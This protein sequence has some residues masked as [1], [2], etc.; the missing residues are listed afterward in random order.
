MQVIEI[1]EVNCFQLN[2]KLTTFLFLNFI[3]TCNEIY[4]KLLLK[5]QTEKAALCYY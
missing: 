5:S 3:K 1:I 2:F 4:L